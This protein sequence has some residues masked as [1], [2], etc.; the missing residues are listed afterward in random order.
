MAKIRHIAIVA[1]DR[2]KVA[3]FYRKGFDMKEVFR[4]Y[5]S[6]SGGEYTI[7]MSD[8]YITLAIFAP[9]PANNYRAEG[10]YHFGFQV[11]DCEQ[12]YETAIAAGGSPPWKQTPRDA[13]G[14]ETFVLDP[15]GTKVDISS[16][17]WR[18]EVEEKQLNSADENLRLRV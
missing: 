12:G 16:R 5:T 8:G 4:H 17:G 2:E 13:R 10:I 1:K 6:D 3:E 14:A 11:D 15:V 18:T 9:S 7:Y